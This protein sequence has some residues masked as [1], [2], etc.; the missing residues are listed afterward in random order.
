[1][2]YQI[3]YNNKK[4]KKYKLYRTKKFIAILVA[5]TALVT[6]GSIYH[7]RKENKKIN[8]NQDYVVGYQDINL[9]TNKITN[10]VTEKNFLLLNVGDH[11]TEGVFFQKQKLE[12]CVQNQIGIGL[13]VTSNS[14]TLADVYLDLEYVKNLMT[15]YPVDYPLYLNVDMF[16]D[17]ENLT[18]QEALN[19]IT[20]FLEKAEE[21]HIFVGVYGSQENMLEEF[22]N[23]EKFIIDNEIMKNNNG[24]VTSSNNKFYYYNEEGEKI[25]IFYDNVFDF[26]KNIYYLKPE[27]KN[28]ILKQSFNQS[29]YFKEDGCYICQKGDTFKSVARKF[30]LSVSDLKKYNEVE[31]LEEGRNLRIPS[32][33]Q[34]SDEE[35]ELFKVGVDVSL[36]QDTISWDDV[37]VDYAIIQLRDFANQENDPQFLNNVLGCQENNIPMGFYVFSRAD[38]VLEVKEEARYVVEQLKGIQV[39]YP[40]YLDLETEFW[41]SIYQ[42]GKYLTNLEDFSNQETVIDFICAWESEIK[43]AGYIPGIYCNQH[44][45]KKLK[46]GV[47]DYL[48]NLAIWIAGGEY[49]DQEIEYDKKENL[50]EV[51]GDE[52]IGMRQVTQKGK[53]NGVDGNVDLDYCYVDYESDIFYWDK[54][55]FP[56]YQRKFMIGGGTSALVL[57]GMILGIRFHKK[58]KKVR[59][60]N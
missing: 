43:E 50:P 1:M 57:G 27:V 28:V 45:Y 51:L 2:E 15:T 42:G 22:S 59:K 36:W 24:G 47:G 30:G 18:Y 10:K 37:S 53:I 29:Y 11:N 25:E 40:I 13:L 54:M 31:F 20:S 35:P 5:A 14:T 41:S 8:S 23:Y 4:G 9:F 48:D 21:Q 16:L 60:K 26:N 52:D 49:Y 56:K 3:K 44:V 34:E 17:N 58:K 6:G 12:Y 55:E 33:V 7:V 39:D 32:F 46:S 19:L 38:T